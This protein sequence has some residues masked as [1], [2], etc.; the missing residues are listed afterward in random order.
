MSCYLADY[1]KEIG[2][3]PLDLEDIEPGMK[4]CFYGDRAY[5]Q[6]VIYVKED[7]IFLNHGMKVQFKEGE[8]YRYV[9]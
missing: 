3:I 4:I 7:M 6:K 8:V 1:L 9:E 5:A 2:H